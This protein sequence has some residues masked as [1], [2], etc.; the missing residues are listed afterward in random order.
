MQGGDTGG[1]LSIF[2]FSENPRLP[3]ARPRYHLVILHHLLMMSPMLPSVFI[4]HVVAFFFALISAL[5]ADTL[6]TS[7]SEP[8][9]ADPVTVAGAPHQRA[10]AVLG[11]RPTTQP[12]S[13]RAA[14]TSFIPHL[15]L[16]TLAGTQLRLAAAAPHRQG[17]DPAAIGPTRH[18]S[19]P[20]HSQPVMPLA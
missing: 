6:I 16:L 18:T 9:L 2:A 7:M 19:P 14:T 20:V 15:T 12:T 11:T 17:H 3:N 4:S 10:L 5:C 1:T 8:T 13:R